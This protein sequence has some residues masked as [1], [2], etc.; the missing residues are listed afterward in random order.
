MIS[1]S[2]I[3]AQHLILGYGAGNGCLH[4]QGQTAPMSPAGTR[5]HI[6][7]EHQDIEMDLLVIF[8]PWRII[9]CCKKQQQLYRLCFGTRTHG[10]G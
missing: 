5:H 1:R 8:L 10:E 6:G 2:Y 7:K 3:T 4:E 9:Q